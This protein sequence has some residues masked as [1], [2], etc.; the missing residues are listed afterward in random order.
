MLPNK[1]CLIAIFRLKLATFNMLSCSAQIIT[2][3][4]GFLGGGGGVTYFT[5]PAESDPSWVT[6]FAGHMGQGHICGH[7][8]AVKGSLP[9]LY[10]DLGTYYSTLGVSLDSDS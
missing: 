5:G 7:Q 9:P 2:H 4:L 6:I 8:G 10:R 1:N 3:Q